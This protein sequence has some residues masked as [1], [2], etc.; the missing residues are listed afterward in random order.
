MFILGFA[1]CVGALRE[2][3]LLLKFVSCFSASEAQ[4][5]F[6]PVDTSPALDVWFASAPGLGSRCHFGPLEAKCSELVT[7]HKYVLNSDP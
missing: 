3:T 6:E 7:H 5:P 1:G 4:T 2:N